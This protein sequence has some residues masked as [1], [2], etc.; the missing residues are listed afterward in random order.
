ML[1]KDID[2]IMATL[3]ECLGKGYIDANELGHDDGA[4][5]VCKNKRGELCGVAIARFSLPKELEKLVG[6]RGSGFLKSVA[7]NESYRNR[8]I[9]MLLA[10]ACVEW[11]ESNGIKTVDSLAWVRGGKCQSEHMLER[12]GFKRNMIVE[13]FWLADSME[14]NYYCPECGQPCVCP[15]VLFT[16]TSDAR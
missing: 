5:L 14:R 12:C 15:A 13:N 2:A 16:R 4:V 11:F 10:T 8:G 7:V 6:I 3:S 1:G 9:G